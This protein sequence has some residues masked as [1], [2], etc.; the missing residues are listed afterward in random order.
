MVEDNGR[1]K[2]FQR[3]G[4]GDRKREE[5]SPSLERV[6]TILVL[7]NTKNSW[8]RWKNRLEFSFS[9]VGDAI[10]A[11]EVRVYLFTTF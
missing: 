8:R 6:V 3:E 1:G 4:E 11:A 2:Q 10:A 5:K 9:A 7:E